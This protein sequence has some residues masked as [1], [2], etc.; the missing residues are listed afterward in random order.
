MCLLTVM[1]LSNVIPT[2]F[3][4]LIY[5]CVVIK[6]IPNKFLFVYLSLCCYQM[7][8]QQVFVCLLI[9]LLL[10]NVFSTSFCLFTY[11]YVVIKCILNKFLFV[12]LP[13]CC[14]QMYSQQ[15]FV[16]LLIVMLL[17]NVFSTSFCLF[18]YRYVVIKCILNK[19]LFVYLS[20]C[21]YQMYSQQ[22]FVCLL[23]VMLLS[24]VFSTSFCAFTYRY[25]VIKCI[26]NKFLCVYLSLCCYQMYSQQ[27]FVCLLIVLLLSNVFSTSFCLFTYRF[28]VIKCILNKFLFV[29][30][31]LCCYQMYSQQVFVRLLIVMLLSNVFSTSFCLFTYRYVVIKCILN[32]FL[33]VYLSLCCYQ[34]YSQQ[35]FVRL[36]IVMLLS[37]VF[38]TSFCAFTY[39]YVVIKCN[40]NK[41]L[42]VY[43][44][45]CCYQM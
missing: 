9:V 35:V 14:Y 1:L 5:R 19:F 33:C 16:C 6:C 7:Y 37:N 20:F 22:V 40:P 8:S 44:S 36:L 26:L 2:S 15:V 4:V 31:P 3:C 30:L 13:L 38:S 27:V 12:Y 10:S 39:R 24:N 41:F 43:L 29:Y 21:C 32:K 28:V 34:M 42:C 23:T 25:V 11:R 17:S 45:L 18:T